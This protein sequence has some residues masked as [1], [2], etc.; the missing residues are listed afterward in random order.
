MEEASA[1]VGGDQQEVILKGAEPIVS[2][3]RRTLVD[4]PATIVADTL[5][6]AAQRL[7]SRRDYLASVQ[8]CSS[9]PEMVDLNA[10]FM[11][12][13]VND[14]GAEAER[15]MEDMRTT[16]LEKPQ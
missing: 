16:L 6:F 14:Y 5:N 12:Q 4:L 15:L 10:K 11:C 7:Q 1:G 3:W 9:V 2:L 13:A 8:S